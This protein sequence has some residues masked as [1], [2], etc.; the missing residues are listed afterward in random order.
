MGRRDF[1]LHNALTYYDLIGL[2]GQ[3]DADKTI[4]TAELQS[5]RTIAAN[6]SQL[7]ISPANANLMSKT[8]NG[9]PADSHYRGAKLA[10]LVAGCSSVVLR[11]LVSKWFLGQD[12]P[13]SGGGYS[14]VGGALFGSSGPSYRDVVQ[15]YLG[16]CWLLASFA[17]TAARMPSVIK[18]MFI[19][20]SNNTWTVRFYINGTPDYVTVNRLL[21]EGG[22]EYDFVAG[23]PLWV[24]LAEKAF[25]QENASGQLQTG[26]PGTNA[27][28]ALDGGYPSVALAA[29]TG[30][31]TSDFY[32]VNGGPVSAA[33][34]QGQLIALTTPFNPANGYIVPNH[35]Y[36][37]V[38]YN[39]TT[40]AV[41]LFN[42][43]GTAGGYL[44]SAHRFYP[45][46]VTVSSKSLATSFDDVATAGTE[47]SQTAAVGVS[48]FAGLPSEAAGLSWQGDDGGVAVYGH[49]AT[50]TDSAAL[51]AVFRALSTRQ[52]QEGHVAGDVGKG[53]QEPRGEGWGETEFRMV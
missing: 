47:A 1:A 34:Q 44:S 31:P 8:V 13:A 11:E 25:A 23:K 22:T 51:D 52:E 41:T 16:D 48:V 37:V 46:Y 6:A 7:N 24:A 53:E 29:I 45:G 21:P 50:A 27:Y 12:L 38:G 42:P 19:A 33:W 26:N 39:K 32:N 30:L 3:A 18:S 40:G 35:S 28:S 49:V 36:A 2:F 17:E 14:T 15:G 20:D 9:D 10:P 4:A 5:L 43:W